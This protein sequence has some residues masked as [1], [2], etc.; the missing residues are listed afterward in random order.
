VK[1]QGKQQ[2]CSGPVSLARERVEEGVCGGT[3]AGDPERWTERYLRTWHA[4]ATATF[5]QRTGGTAYLP[6]YAG[7][8]QPTISVLDREQ[9]KLRITDEEEQFVEW[10]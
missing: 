4:R 10:N 3:A 7:L 2:Y 9:R 5:D 1:N 6:R 8:P